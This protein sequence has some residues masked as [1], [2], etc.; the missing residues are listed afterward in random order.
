MSLDGYHPRLVDARID[1]LLKGPAAIVV[2][3]CRACGKT[4]TVLQVAASAVRLDRDAGARTLG[5]ANPD[6]LL[7]GPQPR[8]I[9]EWQLV[10]EVWNAVRGRVDDDATPGAF[11]LTGSATPSED[12]VRHTGAGRF[13]RVQM[14]PMSLFESGHSSATVH[15]K[16]L[17]ET[18]EL[19]PSLDRVSLQQV[20]LW[21]AR[22]GWPALLGEDIGYA[23]DVNRS[24]L[25][26]VASSDIVTLDGVRRD[27]MKVGALI[28]ALGRNTGTYVSNRVLQTDSARFGSVI[29]AKTIASYL[30]ALQRIWILAVQPTWGGHLRS[31]APARQSPKRHLVDPSLAVAAMGASVNDLVADHETFGQVFETLVFRDLSSYAEADSMSVLAFQDS[32]G[33]EID[34]VIVKGTAWAG[35]EVKL[36]AI[37]QVL[38]AAAANLLSI[39][40]RMTSHPRF[41]AIITADGPTY[42]RPD[43]VHVLSIAHLG[44]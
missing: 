16:D 17:W 44:A 19:V 32:G 4:T 42:T 41:L 8:L 26:A 31:A 25:Q 37:P 3:G 30:D 1:K 22:G 36:A 28:N 43:G 13:I 11:I 18:N 24:Y 9:D 5:L 35:V 40:R 29:E 15:L 21:C 6:G 23:M 38:D 27:P 33:K 39:A 12:Q 2:E 7:D 10:P 20:A 14:R 34:A